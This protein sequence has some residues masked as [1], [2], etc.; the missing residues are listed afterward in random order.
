MGDRMKASDYMKFLGQSQALASAREILADTHHVG[1]VKMLRASGLSKASEIAGLPSLSEGVRRDL[2]SC[3]SGRIRR[4]REWESAFASSREILNA[5]RSLVPDIAQA[6]AGLLSVVEAARIA[7]FLELPRHLEQFRQADHIV[8]RQVASASRLAGWLDSH[9]EIVNSHSALTEMFNRTRFVGRDVLSAI[10]EV[11]IDQRLGFVSTRYAMQFL[12]ISGLLRPPR[13][14]VRTKREKREVLRSL[15]KE[16][17][18]SPEVKK[19]HGLIHRHETV[20]RAIISRCMEIEYGDDWAQIRLPLC[21]CKTL[22][23]RARDGDE[24]VL[25]SADFYHYEKILTHA[26]HFE[27]IFS[28]GFGSPEVVSDLVLQIGRLRSR[29]HHA[30]N[31][32]AEH[33]RALTIALRAVEVGLTELVDDVVIEQ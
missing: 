26:E 18:P 4:N 7:G 13:I 17:R 8:A 22:L 25:N 6:S 2:E 24:D 32:S 30:R 11:L 12:K 20:L 16:S 15:V 1:S 19:A 33:L 14:R 10:D 31:F 3:L 21:E 29:S 27:A 23:G 9:V 28:K 5:S